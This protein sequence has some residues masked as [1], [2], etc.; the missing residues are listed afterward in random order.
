[1]S[2]ES[3][4]I[5]KRS[6][7]FRL[8]DLLVVIGIVLSSVAVLLPAIVRSREAANSTKCKSNLR[9]IAIMIID[10]DGQ[11]GY[12]PR[13]VGTDLSRGLSVFGELRGTDEKGWLIASNTEFSILK[14]PSDDSF[15]AG[16][17]GMSYGINIRGWNG[18]DKSEERF[19]TVDEIPAGAAY[20]VVAGDLAQ[21]GHYG[22]SLPNTEPGSVEGGYNGY[23]GARL[24]GPT[25]TGPDADAVARDGGEVA[26]LFSSFHHE[27][28]VN[29]VLFDGHV[30]TS[31][32][33]GAMSRRENG[34][35]VG[36][37]IIGACHPGYGNRGGE[38]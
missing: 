25:L 29:L 13:P 22:W 33:Q 16:M 17:G 32:R 31:K 38:W 8:V 36:T 7:P 5:K 27:G 23:Y 19:S 35:L 6:R 9:Q 4:S 12:L 37:G 24:T 30:V 10:R 18:F 1:M 26:P 3:P 14:C 15:V 28:A 21:S 2:D 11:V 34:K 20:V